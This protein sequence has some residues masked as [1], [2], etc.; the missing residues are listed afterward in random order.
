MNRPPT[1]RRLGAIRRPAASS[2]NILMAALLAFLLFAGCSRESPGEAGPGQSAADPS[3]SADAMDPA[4]A[5]DSQP[6]SAVQ[7]FVEETAAAPTGVP[8]PGSAAIRSEEQVAAWLAANF[9]DHF[10]KYALSCE[11]AVV[12]LMAAALGAGAMEE[13]QVLEL[14][15]KHPVNPDIGFVVADLNGSIINPDGSVNWANYG[16]HAPVVA[17]TIDRILYENG[18]ADFYRTEIRRLD[19]PE[20]R[21]FL[22]QEDACLAAIIWVAA[23]VEEDEKPPKNERGQVYGEHVQVVS[24]VLDENGKMVVYD[25]WPWEEQPFHL[26]N[27]LNRE[28]FDYQTILIMAEEARRSEPG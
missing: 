11:P 16:A 1:D 18:L 3:A 27:P 21:R 14:M 15:P 20:L 2:L 26:W 7:E 17:S 10:Q 8:A 23:Y 6:D 25:V 19:N 9:T 24:P 22:D 28:L 12:R 5:G 13:E 4:D